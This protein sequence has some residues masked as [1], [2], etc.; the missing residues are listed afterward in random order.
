MLCFG[1][2]GVVFFLQ[3]NEVKGSSHMELAGLK[4]AMG[5]LKDHVNI[6]TLVTDRHSMVKKYMKDFHAEKNRYFCFGTLQKVIQVNAFLYTC[7]LRFSLSS[8]LH[9]PL[10]LLYFTKVS[11]IIIKKGQR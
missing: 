4:R 2:F 11:H 3:S 5:F 8:Y 10:L 1:G 7:I 9:N 6:K